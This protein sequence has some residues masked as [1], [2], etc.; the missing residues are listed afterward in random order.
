MTRIEWSELVLES[1]LAVKI[2]IEAARRQR[3]WL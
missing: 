2:A 3:T 1:K